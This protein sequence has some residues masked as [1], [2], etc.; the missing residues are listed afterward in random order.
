M[1][2][3]HVPFLLSLWAKIESVYFKEIW[4]GRETEIKHPNHI[5]IL[6]NGS[7][8]T[9]ALI[10]CLLR[11]DIPT[12]SVLK[13][14][15]TTNSWGIVA[16]S[17]PAIPDPY[18][19]VRSLNVCLHRINTLIDR[20]IASNSYGAPTTL[21]TKTQ[22][23]DIHVFDVIK[24]AISGIYHKIS[25]LI[26]SRFY[27]YDHWQMAYSA[28]ANDPK[29]DW[30]LF[31]PKNDVLQADPFLWRNSDGAI[32]IF[33][34]YMP[35]TTNKGVINHIS[36]TPDT[37][38]FG[39]STTVLETPYHLSFPFLFEYQ[40]QIYMIPETGQNRTIE[41]YKANP[42]PST[43]EP[44]HIAMNDVIANDTVLYFDGELWW[45]FTSIGVEGQKN[46][47]ELSLFYSTQPFGEWT[48]H[49]K[50]PIKS[51]CRSARMAGNIFK[52]SHGRLIRPAQNCTH[53]YGVSIAL[54]EIT[55]L[56]PTTYHEHIVE[57]IKSPDGHTGIHTWNHLDGFT[58]FDVKNIQ[59]K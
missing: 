59:R 19:F 16:E 25:S 13:F 23:D 20:A 55:E 10:Q 49:P 31:F 56:N 33:F 28:S 46:W 43:W 47:D 45:M 1:I 58:I 27:Q 30:T 41:I 3:I 7:I 26:Q 11:H 6:F 34:E 17:Y 42:F 32:H 39:P 15:P 38:S 29:K 5:K 21:P 12:I 54:C 36:Y 51:D 9:N 57:H 44:C 24:F 14:N 2:S 35:Y 50:N 37:G 4:Q 22:I 48:P 8:S 18:V 52:D 53:G 40:E